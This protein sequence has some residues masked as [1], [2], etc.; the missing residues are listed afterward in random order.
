MCRLFLTFQ[1]TFCL[2]W[3]SLSNIFPIQEKEILNLHWYTSTPFIYE[4][5]SGQLVG[6]EPDML[7][8]FQKYLKE[9]EG[10][11]LELNWI[12]ANSFSHILSTVKEVDDE[13]HIG[14]IC[15]FCNG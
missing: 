12:K 6:I 13:K 11:E 14:S 1:F 7:R 3:P 2:C 5:A 8:L 15:A 9:E 10:I 4:D